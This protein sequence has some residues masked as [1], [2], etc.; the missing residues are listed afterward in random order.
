MTEYVERGG[1]VIGTARMGMLGRHG[2]YNHCMPCF[3]LQKVF[4]IDALEAYSAVTPE[5][6]YQ[7]KIY[8]G[9]WHKEI[10]RLT[11]PDV[12]VLARFEDDL[13]AVTRHKYGKGAA[14][15]FATHPDAAWLE[16]E[17]Y[18]LWD[19][20]DRMLPE[21]GVF[22]KVE[23]FFSQ[24]HLREFD[25]NLIEGEKEGYLIITSSFTKKFAYSANG[26]RLV[27]VVI[28][29]ERDVNR[30]EGLVGGEVYKFCLHAGELRFSLQMRKNDSEVVRIEYK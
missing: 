2:W 17:S 5:I 1:T 4:G 11:E 9:S 20:L 16:N 10:L 15:Y 24:R 6:T 27:E 12:E 14:V 19:I 25:G 26:R 18:L 22:P 13:P 29:T 23:L 8:Q 3:A 21:I 7:R 28:R 30:V